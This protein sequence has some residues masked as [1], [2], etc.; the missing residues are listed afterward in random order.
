MTTLSRL[1]STKS[2]RAL[3]LVLFLATML[4]FAVYAGFDFARLF[5]AVAHIDVGWA[6]AAL[7]AFIAAQIFFA[8]RWSAMITPHAHPGFFSVLGHMLIGNMLN[9]FLP[10]RAGD[11]TRAV[12][13]SRRYGIKLG[14]TAGTVALERIADAGTVCLMAAYLATRLTIPQGSLNAIVAIAAAIIGLGIALF[15]SGA[16]PRVFLTRIATRLLPAV[17]F[18]KLASLIGGIRDA[19]LRLRGAHVIAKAGSA[20]VLGWIAVA[21]AM[22]CMLASFA[23]DVPHPDAELAV[24]ALTGLGSAVIQ[25][26]AGIGTWH[27]LAATALALWQVPVEQGIAFALVAH[28]IGVIVPTIGGA[29]T[30]LV[31][32][33]SG[34]ASPG[35]HSASGE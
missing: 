22:S 34:F 30:Y 13:L 8:M 35:A 27:V 12:M 28:G 33:R 14:D 19:V 16:I 18:Q 15:V 2:A 10:M 31:F 32:G 1:L 26:P 5:D 29:I 17:L 23:I 11:V 21:V 9:V 6:L 20:H 4:V 7:V 25:V 24:I 3:I